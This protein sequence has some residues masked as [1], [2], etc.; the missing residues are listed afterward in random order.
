MC[1][2][3]IQGA[4]TLWILFDDKSFLELGGDVVLVTEEAVHAGVNEVGGRRVSS[5]QGR[6]ALAC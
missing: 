2:S 1:A 5:R 4:R 3:L 6:L